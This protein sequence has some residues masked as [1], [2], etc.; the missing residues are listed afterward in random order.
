[1]RRVL[2]Q[3]Y[4]FSIPSSRC[5]FG[6]YQFK[7]L[8]QNFYDAGAKKRR[9]QLVIAVVRFCELSSLSSH[10]TNFENYASAFA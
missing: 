8:V 9:P 10:T 5:D 3:C 1:M 2:E 7:A 4:R 6:A